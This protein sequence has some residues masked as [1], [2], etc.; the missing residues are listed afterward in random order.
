MAQSKSVL[1]VG[2]SGFIGTHLALRLRDYFKVFA[3][4][5]NHRMKIP[6]VTCVPMNLE[7]RNWMKRIAYLARPDAVIYLAGNTLEGLSRNGLRKAEMVHGSGP[8]AVI[9]AADIIQP[10]FIFLSSSY[11]FDGTRG[12]YH[13]NDTILPLSLYGKIKASGENGIKSK[14]LNYIILRSSPVFGRGSGTH[15]SHFDRL[16]MALDRNER[17][18]ASPYEIHSFAP[19]E[20]LCETIHRIIDSG[21]RNRAFHYGGLTKMTTFEFATEFAK[22]FGYDPSLIVPKGIILGKSGF[23]DDH[24]YDFSLNSTQTIETLKIKP[25]FLEEGFDLIQKKLIPKF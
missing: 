8:A 25:F 22:R 19:I 17:F 9:A 11:V 23:S 2:G 14:S 15:L 4:Y 18:E 13:E 20:G 16:R 12:N 1:I 10:K 5:C 6:G 24:V 3:T 7:S 21:A